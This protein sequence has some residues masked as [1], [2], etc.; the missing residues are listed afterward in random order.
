MTVKPSKPCHKTFNLCKEKLTELQEDF[1]EF[2]KNC[3]KKSPKCRYLSNI[4]Y[5]SHLL[6]TL[7]AADT[8]E[9]WGRHLITT[10]NLIA[11][12]EQI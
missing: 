12:F 10:K 1:L 3:N 2:S 4:L 11:I 7:V 6:K 9:D 5:M 8:T